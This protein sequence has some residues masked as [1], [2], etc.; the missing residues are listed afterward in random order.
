MLS[1]SESM[2]YV[3]NKDSL[4]DRRNMTSYDGLSCRLVQRHTHRWFRT[5][6]KSV[7]NWFR[8]TTWLLN[9]EQRHFFC[10]C[11]ARGSALLVS[12]WWLCSIPHDEHLDSCWTAGIATDCLVPFLSDGFKAP[13]WRFCLQTLQQTGNRLWFSSSL[14]ST[15]T[16]RDASFGSN[17]IY[18]CFA[19]SKS[20]SPISFTN[21]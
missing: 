6:L 12:V 3:T 9:Y 5:Q 19:N 13:A 7:V 1:W 4:S 16:V 10:C 17:S 21:T 18:N 11:C 14:V 2:T 20:C 15:L 8:D